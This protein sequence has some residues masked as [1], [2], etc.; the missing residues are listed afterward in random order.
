MTVLTRWDPF[1][2][3]ARVQ[4]EMNRA[5]GDERLQFGAGDSVGWTPACDIYEDGEEIV[6]RAEL[7]GV[8][9]GA[10]EI[11]FENGVLT[12][13]GERKLEKADRRENY[14]RLE[15][16]YGTFTRAFSMPATIDTEKIRAESKQGVLH[17]HLPKKPEAKPKS[18]QVKAS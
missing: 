1:R 4:E 14:H 18:I 7:A 12:L 10:V 3:L 16:S 9:P 8:E 6:V 15:L 2:E 13:K 5:L 17:V 11:R